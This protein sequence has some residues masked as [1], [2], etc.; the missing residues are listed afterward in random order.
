MCAFAGRKC[1]KSY[2]YSYSKN[3]RVEMARNSSHDISLSHFNTVR[4]SRRILNLS[5]VN[6]LNLREMAAMFVF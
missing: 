1:H 2:I 3:R 4:Q 5:L 6:I